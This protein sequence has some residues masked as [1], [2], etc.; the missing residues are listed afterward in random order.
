MAAL[1]F[2]EPQLREQLDRLPKE[3]RA[4]FAA[5]CAERLFPAYERFSEEAGRGDPQ[6]LR[7]ALSRLWED[8][9]CDPLSELE[10]HASPKNC[11]A[12]VPPEDEE[13]WAESQ[14]SA[15][16][17][18]AALVYALESR[19]K[20]DSQEAAWSAR[21]AYDALDRFLMSDQPGVIVT[22]AAEHQVQEHPLVQAELARQRRDLDELLAVRDGDVREVAA[23]L[24]DRAKEESRAFFGA[25]ASPR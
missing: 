22:A 12:L 25:A 17:A 10:L 21:R 1:R 6:T 2:V 3:H 14:P 23:R 16:D 4:A 13:P 5:S 9:A 20:D 24:R 8:L 7:A 15:D 18:A 11:L 19:V